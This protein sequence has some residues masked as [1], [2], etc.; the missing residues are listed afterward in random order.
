MK[1][2]LST[3]SYK[4]SLISTCKKIK[5]KE[6]KIICYDLILQ[7]YARILFYFIIFK[8]GAQQGVAHHQQGIFQ[9]GSVIINTIKYKLHR[10]IKQ[11]SYE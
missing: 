7:R 6:R 10:K 3:V 8:Q 4:V 2:F 11:N 1:I 5:S 9:R